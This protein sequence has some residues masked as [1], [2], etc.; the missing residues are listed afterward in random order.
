MAQIKLLEQPSPKSAS[1]I[2]KTLNEAKL[3]E[4][5]ENEKVCGSQNALKSNQQKIP[6]RQIRVPYRR[7][8]AV[9][10]SNYQ[11]ESPV[12]LSKFEPNKEFDSLF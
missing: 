6:S 5:A 11:S 7:R 9:S 2:L 8:V 10:F 3:S 12:V 4:T 1:N